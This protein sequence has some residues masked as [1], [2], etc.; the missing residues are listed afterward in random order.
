[1]DDKSNEQY[2]IGT[3]W[4]FPPT[5]NSNDGTVMMTD[6]AEDIKESLQILFSTLV[7][8]RIMQPEYGCDIQHFLFRSPD[9]TMLVQLKEKISFAILHFEPRI[10]INGIDTDINNINDGVILISVDYTIRSTNSR[11]NMIFPYYQ[12]EGTLIQKKMP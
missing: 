12:N 2:F 8:E 6:G 1:M 10:T 5:F 4:S 7:G 11:S 3:G 9:A